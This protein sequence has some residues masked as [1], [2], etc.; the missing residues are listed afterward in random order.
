MLMVAA[1]LVGATPR[2]DA[3]QPQA[4]DAKRVVLQA[5]EGLRHA[6]RYRMSVVSTGTEDMPIT[7][8]VQLPDRYRISVKSFEAAAETFIGETLYIGDTRQRAPRGA[9]GDF[10]LRLLTID[11]WRD[12]LETGATSQIGTRT[13][14]GTPHVLLY[15]TALAGSDG[16][17]RV[18]I[19][20]KGLPV[21][22]ERVQND[23][24]GRPLT[25]TVLV[26]HI[27]DDSIRVDPPATTA[28]PP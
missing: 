13:L 22:L 18:W 3:A 10:L 20:R 24:H 1:Q 17:L 11:A 14:R 15:R 21:Q 26:S 2:P 8:D 5:I 19:D 9:S 12:L 27:G 7:I 28:A 16:Q 25:M 6:Q 23:E 4:D